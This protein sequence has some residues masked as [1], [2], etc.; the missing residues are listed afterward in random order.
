[1]GWFEVFPRDFKGQGTENREPNI[2]NIKKTGKKRKRAK[3]ALCSLA[4]SKM[5]PSLG[6]K[7]ADVKR[8]KGMGK[9]AQRCSAAAEALSAVEKCNWLHIHSAG[10][11]PS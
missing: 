1:M 8:T 3:Q 11:P 10:V 6:E 7:A 2:T 4:Y 5:L 9:V